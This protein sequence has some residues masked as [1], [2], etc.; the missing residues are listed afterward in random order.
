MQKDFYRISD[1]GNNNIENNDVPL[2]LNCAGK[3]V[4]PTHQALTERKDYYLFYLVDGEVAV[5]RPVEAN[6]TAGDMIVFDKNTVFEYFASKPTTHFYVH[7]T[8]NMAATLLEQ[9]NIK[10]STA[11]TVGKSESIVAK[12]YKIFESFYA[13]DS[14]FDVDI[15]GKLCDLLVSFGRKITKNGQEDLN[16][17]SKRLR[18]SLL[19]INENIAKPIQ[20]YEL[21]EIEKLSISR[22]Q[23]LF[24]SVFNMSP[25]QYVTKAK[26]D[27]ACDLLEKT[28]L[29]IGEVAEAVGYED[30]RYFSRVFKKQ[31][32]I[33]PSEYKKEP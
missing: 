6:L 7:F 29:S 15:A 33:T 18:K 30:Y 20:L 5:K 9:C 25:G 24:K 1:A 8:G 4:L 13:R 19:F 16:S 31:K 28:N 27:A 3:N 26:M 23:T 12:I 11:Y 10:V 14:F 22:Y 21:A 17:N 32:G 2:Q